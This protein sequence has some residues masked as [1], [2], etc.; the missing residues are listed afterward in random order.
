ME[1]EN[2]AKSDENDR[3]VVVIVGA[4]SKHGRADVEEEGESSNVEDGNDKSSSRRSTRWGL[5]GAL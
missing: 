5:G 3:P 1:Q 2:K 4:S